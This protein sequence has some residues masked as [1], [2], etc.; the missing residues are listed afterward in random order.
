MF[1]V[2]LNVVKQVYTGAAAGACACWVLGRRHTAAA[3]VSV[4][5]FCVSRLCQLLSH[6]CDSACT[7]EYSHHPPTHTLTTNQPASQPASP[8]T[9]P[10]RT[11]RTEPNAQPADADSLTV[12]CSL[13]TA[14]SLH[15]WLLVQ[16]RQTN[17]IAVAVAVAFAV[18]VAVAF[19]VAFFCC[20]C[21]GMAGNT[22]G[23][24]VARWDGA[25]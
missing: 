24:T 7:C 22:N 1:M 4:S 14:H 8:P 13:F 10:N 6:R 19:A 11:D 5:V 18:A 21:G 3:A 16:S 20:R 2:V 12:H 23:G 15:C 25:D 17:R 9:H